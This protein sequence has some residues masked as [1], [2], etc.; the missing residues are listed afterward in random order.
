MIVVGHTPGD[1]SRIE[2]GGKLIA[3]DSSLSRY[4][5]RSG[6]RY[7]PTTGGVVGECALPLGEC[8]GSITR[9]EWDEGGWRREVLSLGGQGGGKGEL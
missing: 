4:F 3:S 1:E 5:D 8:R 2:C 9:V 6:N 7:C